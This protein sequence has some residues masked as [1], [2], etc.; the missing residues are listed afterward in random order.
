MGLRVHLTSEVDSF[1]STQ[2]GCAQTTQGQ[3]T[4]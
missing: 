4:V 1:E 2:Q 3:S